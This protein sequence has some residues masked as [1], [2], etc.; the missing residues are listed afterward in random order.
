METR[1]SPFIVGL[2]TLIVL[3][4]VLG[5]VFWI[6]RYG[7]AAGREQYRVVF[8][9]EVTGLNR[10]SSVLFNGIRV[11][12]VVEMT[13]AADDPSQVVALIQV[14]SSVPV[15]VDTRAQLQF[16]GITG[17]AFV[18]LK[19]GKQGA[20]PLRE[21]WDDPDTPPIIYAE[22]STFQDLLEGAQ[23]LLT[24]LDTVADDITGL[25]ADN[26][27]SVSN[28]IRNVENF[29]G[30]L[31]ENSEAISGFMEDAASAARRLDEVGAQI[32]T[33]SSNANVLLEAVDPDSVR[34]V[35]SDVRT[36]TDTLA[37]N[38]DRISAFAESAGSAAE[39]LNR[40]AERLET[41]G[42]DVGEVV[43]AVDPAAVSRTVANI[44][45]FSNTVA[46]R[47]EDVDKFIDDAGAVA[48]ELRG[49]SQRL[50]R[51]LARVDNMVGQEGDGFMSD[52]AAAARSVR[53]LSQSLNSRL[54][55]ITADIQR[56]GGGGLREFERLMQ[57]GRRTLSNLESVIGEL[58]SNPTGFLFG[59]SK[60]PEYNPGRRF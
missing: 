51:I 33:L 5:F 12:D 23:N 22:R 44:E 3:A 10:G 13:L 59:G 29:T 7:D 32:E 24:K 26:R 34:A 30:A 58:E 11:G 1:A 28:T 19:P 47:S 38:A 39:R 8:S 46:G 4:G 9:D 57:D 50:D 25:V 54:D 43:S 40:L 60:V 37:S 15:R 42:Q 14:D 16:Q 53:E 2:F 52:I 48:T 45:Q 27:T 20:Q 35:V 36:F 6:G 56:F 31:A 49:A 55:V 17:V 41:I 18:Q 21:A